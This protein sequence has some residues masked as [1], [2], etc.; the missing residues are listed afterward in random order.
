MKMIRN[1]F[2][3][4]C[5]AA[6]SQFGSASVRLP[7]VISSNMVLQRDIPVKIW[8]ESN[9]GEKVTIT[10]GEQV[11]T[12]TTSENGKWIVTLDPLKSSFISQNLKISTPDKDT[13]LT[14]IL[15]GEVW[16]CGGQSNMEY[17]MRRGLKKYSAPAR[18]EDLADA[19]WRSGGSK[20][21]RLMIVEKKNSLPDCT[22]KGWEIC[23]DSSLAPFSAV[24]Y[25]FGKYLQE[26][27]DVPVGLIS[28]NW[29]GSRIE[30][31]TP[32]SSY[33][34]SAIFKNETTVKPVIID[35]I[36]AGLHYNSMIS[37]LG[38]YGIRGF[39]WY[40]GESNLMIHD[41][42]YV[43]K[44]GLLID[45]WRKLFENP[46]APFYY[47]QVAPYSYTKR[48]DKL[49]H[50]PETMAEFCELQT[51][52]LAIPGTGQVIVTDLVDDLSNIHPSYKWEV[53]RRLSLIALAKTYG[54]KDLVFSGPV[55]KSQNIKKNKII[56]TF[57]NIG[58]GLTAGIHNQQTSEFQALNSTDLDW[59]TIAGKDGKFY[60][61][62]AVI[63]NSQ[64]VVSSPEVKK[65]K[66]VRFAWDEKAMPNFF[67]KEGLPAVPFRTG[68]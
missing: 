50:T 38:P 17:P 66:F 8:G 52:C 51:K 43:E 14:N 4:S 23:S 53:G 48:K 36:D 2:L 46:E 1:F 7:R 20:N 68:L 6:F 40:Q 39:I 5:I 45:A 42:R 63:K 31:W 13:V 27:L 28:S 32:V 57:D 29:G 34:N 37:P 59:F 60:T 25:Y 67:N 47:V 19:E 55:F 54:K 10:F 21:V 12:A 16:L 62:K 35:G 3:L 33:E 9:P 65:P 30:R 11:R 49:S 26:E 41:K 61:A 15:V 44:S 56:L 22:S 18:G 58:A 24:G 64:V